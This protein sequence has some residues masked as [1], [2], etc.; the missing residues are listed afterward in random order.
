[1]IGRTVIDQYVIKRKLGEGG[2]GAVYLADQPAVGRQAVI[3]VMH[4]SLSRDPTVATRFEVEARAASQL[5][6]PHIITIYNYGAMQDSTLFLA[7]E[8]CSGKSLE[9]VVRGGAVS[10]QRATEI[11]GQI[12]D[13]LAEAHRRGVVHRDLK[14]SNII[15][16]EMGRH[17]DYVKVLDFGIAKMEGVKLTR[18]GSVIGTPQYMSPEQLR[19]DPLDGR[20]DI[21]SLGV[22]L[23]E[24]VAGQLPFKSDSAAGYMH[25]HLNEVPVSPTSIRQ[26]IPTNLA[27]IILKALAKDPAGRFQDADT[28][29]RALESYTI[30]SE[31]VVPITGPGTAA[32]RP[33]RKIGLWL[34]VGGSSLVAIGAIVALVFVLHT[35]K[36]AVSKP[37]PT[38]VAWRVLDGSAT[39]TAPSS[40]G[41]VVAPP[42]ATVRTDSAVEEKD[43]PEAERPPSR[44]KVGRK[45]SRNKPVQLAMSREPRSKPPAASGST[46]SPPSSPPITP[47]PPSPAK[48]PASRYSKMSGDKLEKELR[49]VISNAKIPPS[50]ADQ[51]F[52]GYKQSLSLWPAAQREASRKRYLITMIQAYKRPSLQYKPNERKSLA[53]LRRIFLTMKTKANLSPEQMAKILKSALSSYDRPTINAKDRDFYKRLALL[54]MIKNMAA[55][56]AQA[57]R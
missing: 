40:T 34:A 44:A 57:L 53:Q 9:E 23:Y 52:K 31:S 56:P 39:R 27:A 21:Y 10:A 7:M 1:M 50:T 55:D 25:K 51:A 24:L 17:R 54:A 22:M 11:G 16:T 18:T 42:V 29:G 8:Y 33:G 28:F 36:S 2:M 32:P 14:P 20:S 3:K 12:C 6:H 49:R 46:T 48:G 19:G 37:D 41:H 43:E 15:L 47:T 4:P 45:R 30:G 38:R 13:A 5:N 35:D 26:N